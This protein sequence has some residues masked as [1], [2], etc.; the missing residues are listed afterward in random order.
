VVGGV[1]AL[2]NQQNAEGSWNAFGS[3]SANSTAY[4]MQGL[5]AAGENLEAIRWLENGHSPYNALSELQKTDGPFTYG[6]TDDFF[7]TRQA[8]PALL[9]VH[10][11]FAHTLKPFVSVDRGPDPDRTVAADLDVSWNS[12]ADVVVPFGSDLDADGNVTLTWREVGSTSWETETIHRAD[13]YYT[14]TL[15]LALPGAYELQATFVDP[16]SVQYGTVV[17]D[18]VSLT[19]TL[20][21]YDIFLPLVLRQ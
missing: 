4:A 16:D 1:Q 17:S 20:A 14:A 13:G 10:Y 2:E 9:G 21:R 6:V 11:P 5:L 7:A 15:D 18:S 12:S 3:P 8:V 19:T